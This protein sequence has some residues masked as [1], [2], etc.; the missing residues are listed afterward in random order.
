MLFSF[1]IYMVPAAETPG[2]QVVER[3]IVVSTIISKFKI[4]FAQLTSRQ[5]LNEIPTTESEQ[6]FC[7][8]E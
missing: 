8:L 4:R 2:V 3:Q 1:F 5:N 7:T 6:C